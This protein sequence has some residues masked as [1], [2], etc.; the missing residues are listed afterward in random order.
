MGVLSLRS[1]SVGR[2]TFDRVRSTQLNNLETH[3]HE[4]KVNHNDNE[5]F[6][7]GFMLIMFLR[8]SARGLKKPFTNLTQSQVSLQRVWQSVNGYDGA[9]RSFISSL[10]A[11]C[12]HG[13]SLWERQLQKM[14]TYRNVHQML[15][16]IVFNQKKAAKKKKCIKTAEMKLKRKFLI[17]I[18]FK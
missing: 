13:K 15:K 14:Y 1:Y 11:L 6:V 7:F 18:I 10:L 4:K 2:K 8:Q 5:L 16:H 17:N 3:F 12:L 9:V